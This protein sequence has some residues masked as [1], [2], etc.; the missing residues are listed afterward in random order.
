MRQEE[1]SERQFILYGNFRIAAAASRNAGLNLFVGILYYVQRMNF[2]ATVD[3]HHTTLQTNRFHFRL[4][5]VGASGSEGTRSPTN[6]NK[7]KTIITDIII[8]NITIAQASAIIVVGVVHRRSSRRH[9]E[10]SS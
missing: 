8:N 1:S 5:A 7:T 3:E 2:V 6:E 10:L 9:L 4:Q